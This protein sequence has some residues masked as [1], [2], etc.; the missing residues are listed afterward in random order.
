MIVLVSSPEEP[1]LAWLTE[2][3]G[4][5]VL[6]Q[7]RAVYTVRDGDEIRGVYVITWRNDATAELHVYGTVTPATTRALFSLAFVGHRLHRLEVITSR[8]NRR[9][10]K[11]AP[12]MGFRFECVLKDYY[13]PGQ[14]GFLYAMTPGECRWIKG[15]TDGIDVQST[16]TDGP[17]GADNAGDGATAVP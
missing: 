9:I 17:D 2:H 15:G 12:K 14:D 10:R 5:Y 16:G 3:H 13:G 1:A 6:Q 8:E 4:V 11:A 7:P